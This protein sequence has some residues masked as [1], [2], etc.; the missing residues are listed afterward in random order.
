MRSDDE[1]PLTMKDLKM[2]NKY[3]SL[4]ETFYFNIFT[5][6]SLP[7]LRFEKIFKV[8]YSFFKIIDRMSM[9]LLPFSKRYSWICVMKMSEPIKG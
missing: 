8:I 1:H 7:F 2:A 6:F 9:I 4:N 3:F 5:F